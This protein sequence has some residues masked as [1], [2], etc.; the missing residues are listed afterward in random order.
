MPQPIRV[1]PEQLVQAAAAVESSADDVAA[2]HASVAAAAEAA[3]PGLVG[4]STEAIAGMVTNWRDTSNALHST[5]SSQSETIANL[6]R[7]YAGTEDNNAATVRALTDGVR[8]A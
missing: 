4:R 1:A 6:A 8:P 3:Q 2:V 7:G 5:M